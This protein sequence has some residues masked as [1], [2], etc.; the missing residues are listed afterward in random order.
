MGYDLSNSLPLDFEPNGIPFDS[1]SKG[2]LPPRSYP[3]QCERKFKHSFLSVRT[4]RPI[5]KKSAGM[6]HEV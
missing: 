1:K 5:S 2:K 3:I 6:P 4:T